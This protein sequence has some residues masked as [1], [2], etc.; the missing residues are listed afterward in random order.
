LSK[1]SS[2]QFRRLALYLPKMSSVLVGGVVVL[3][4]D[5]AQSLPLAD[6][7]VGEGCLVGG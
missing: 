7:E 4:E 5:V 3:V 2:E 6:V 1:I